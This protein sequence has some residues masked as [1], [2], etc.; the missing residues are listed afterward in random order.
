MKWLL[1]LLMMALPLQWFLVAGPLRLHIL[2]MLGFLVSVVV[3]HRGRAFLPVL[4]I[5]WAFVV[6]N[7]VLCVV[8]LGTNAYNGLAPRGPVQQ[9][10]YL[11]V[12]VAVGTT[13]YRGTTLSRLG[14]VQMMRWTAL[15]T[16][17]SLIVA[18]SYSMS[19]NGVNP[20]EVLVRTT[21]S[22]DP[23][24]LQRELFRSAFIGFGFDD[25]GVRGNFRH[26]VFG[27]VLVAMC[28]SAACVSLRPFSSTV[29]RGLY[30]F[31]IA[32]GATL[33]VLSMSRSVMIAAA[34]WPLLGLLKS[35]L[36]GRLSPRVVGGAL[37]AAAVA[38]A[39]AVLGFLNVLWVRFTQDTSSYRARDRLLAEAWDNIGSNLLTGGVATQGASSH[40]FV[41]DNWL[42]SGLFGA[43]AALAVTV[44][45]LGLFLG[46]AVNLQH[47]PPWML[48]VIALLAL[49]LVRLFTAGGGLIP[50]VQWVALGVVAGFLAHR[51]D[52]RVARADGRTRGLPL[53][54]PDEPADGGRSPVGDHRAPPGENPSRIHRE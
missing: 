43:A 35:V 37:V 29:S 15:L 48:P 51:A 9:L 25:V 8:W 41:I 10:A 52:V 32:L 12:F 44:M 47:E 26:E 11:A 2:V 7:L 3:S 53:G 54:S 14:F 50:P 40:N 38:T 34:A 17:V 22:G 36:S 1:V 31:S 28:L 46:L 30:R 24:I 18:L 20:A 21:A 49:P 6:G 42:R 4:R 23:E 39:L 5:S 27:S 19:V 45:V 16:S 33:L 13:V